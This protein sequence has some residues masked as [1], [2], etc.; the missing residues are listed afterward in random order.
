MSLSESF[1]SIII[2]ATAT[3]A[4]TTATETPSSTSSEP[5]PTCTTAKP[6]PNGH[7]PFDACNSYYNV[8]PQFAPAVAVAVIFGVLSTIHI[9]EAFIF[10][11]VSCK[12][13]CPAYHP[14]MY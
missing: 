3:I 11:K 2:S 14:N 8:E 5:A 12:H 7:V 1:T 6:G 4:S 9:A 10:S 13:P